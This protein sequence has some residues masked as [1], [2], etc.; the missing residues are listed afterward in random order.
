MVLN[1]VRRATAT[2]YRSSKSVD[3]WRTIPPPRCTDDSITFIQF[4]TDP[5]FSEHPTLSVVAIHG[6]DVGSPEYPATTIAE[7]SD[8]GATNAQSTWRQPIKSKRIRS[9]RPISVDQIGLP[10]TA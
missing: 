3:P 1:E 5:Q 8:A 4:Q 7:V 9:T 10:R 2:M 6:L